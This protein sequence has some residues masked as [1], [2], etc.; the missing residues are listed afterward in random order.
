MKPGCIIVSAAGITRTCRRTR[1]MD[2]ASIRR[3]YVYTD[4]NGD[5]CLVARGT[6]L[7][8]QFISRRELLDPTVRLG[9]TALLDAVAAN[10]QIDATVPVYLDALA[11]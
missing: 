1:T 9:V 10:A 8:L 5:D 2:A 6:R 7:R 4:A 11:A 3:I